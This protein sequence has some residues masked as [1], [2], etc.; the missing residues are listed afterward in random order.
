MK[1]VFKDDAGKKI[2]SFDLGNFGEV[3]RGEKPAI[4][5]K[6]AEVDIELSKV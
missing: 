6:L 1:K 5:G 4:F 2:E 3:E